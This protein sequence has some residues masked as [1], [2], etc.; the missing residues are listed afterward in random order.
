MWPFAFTIFLSAFLL[1][2][3]QPIIA[4]CILPAY[5]GSSAV[6]T[7]C[8]LFFQ[9]FLLIGYA[10]AHAIRLAL[11]PRRQVWVHAV[12]MA[13]ALGTLPMTPP[14]SLAPTG[15]ENPLWD[16][17]F[18]LVQTVGAPYLMVS[19]S[20]P[21]LQHWFS[22]SYPDRSPYRLYALSNVGSLIGLL[23]YPFIVEPWLGLSRQTMWWSIG[24]VLY[25]V[26]AIV[27][28]R[29][30][31]GLGSASSESH[32]IDASPPPS[33]G[34]RA[35]WVALAACGSTALL[36]ITNQVCLDVAVV[37]FLWVIP[38]ALYLLSFI[39]CFERAQWYHRG[40]WVPLF[41]VT[42]IMAA[43]VLLQ[44]YTVSIYFQMTAYLSFL[45]CACMVCHGEVV[46]LKPE[47]DRLTS[48]YLLIALGGALGGA[49]VNI[50]APLLFQGYWEL[51]VVMLAIYAILGWRLLAHRPLAEGRMP[52]WIQMSLWST[53]AGLLAACLSAQA[54]GQRDKLMVVTRNFY[55]VL[56]VI[57]E[58][59]HPDRAEPATLDD[60]VHE[61]AWRRSLLHGRIL[62][63]SQLMDKRYRRWPTT[64]Y[65][66]G[67]GVFVALHEHP[68]EAA[69]LKVGVV[70]LG[71]GTI[72]ALADRH[73]DLQDQNRDRFVY[74]E[75]NPAVKV[76]ADRY[77]SYLK[78]SPAKIDVLFG[79]AR[80][81]MD[82]Q[83]KAGDLQKFDVL[84]VDAFNGDSIPMHLLTLEAMQ[85]YWSHLKPDGILA[86]HVSN[87]YLNLQP[88][89]RGLG[90]EMGHQAVWIYN[91]KDPSRSVNTAE[92]VLVTSNQAFL[93]SAN[94]RSAIE[95][96]PTDWRIVWSDDH[97]NLI[98]VLK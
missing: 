93:E 60:V 48:F 95:P 19:A 64:F 85:L 69:G 56:S 38:L 27:C 51:H 32:T 20:G 6:W 71:T 45:F 31:V 4:R 88:V 94:V 65:G 78:D 57:E 24:F 87:L 5:G 46:R 8:M 47:S 90:E 33:I 97:S 68:K 89:V 26:G 59:A 43:Y 81:V 42:L 10:Y 11:T 30:V 2:Q 18:L 34:D 44:P 98:S 82:R 79:D 91:R 1:F 7:A 29:S 53:G 70:G 72:A 15:T 36:A 13:M 76:I 96:W 66:R 17:F 63:G 12:L 92:W 41:L 74:Y 61:V 58:Y 67:T 22:L 55:G 3:V 9:V 54:S 35:M 39:V 50:V 84:V 28:G 80:V 14:T 73:D 21:L 77:F 49:F 23:A 16:I 25:I 86:V 40:I 52:V 37:P 75:I 62:H 83:R